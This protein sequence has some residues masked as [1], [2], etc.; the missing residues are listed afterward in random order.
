[1][2]IRTPPTAL[3]VWVLVPLLSV[4]AAPVPAARAQFAPAVHY[5]AGDGPNSVAIGDLDGDQVPDLAMTTYPGWPASGGSV[6]VLLGLG[7]GMFADAVHYAAG[8]GP[9]S[10]AIGDLDG[11]QVPDLAVA[12]GLSDSVSVL[13]GLGD[14][15]FAA[16]A[17]YAAGDGPL[18]VSIGD[19]DGDQI[20]D[21]AVASLISNNVSVLLGLG[22]GT[23]AA[24]KHY[25]AGDEPRSVAIGDLDGDQVLDLAV[26][27]HWYGSFEDSTVSVLLGL[28]D[29]TFAAAVNYPVG[30]WPTSVAIGDLDGDQDSDLVVIASGV[31]SVLLGVGNG[32][33][34]ATRHYYPPAGDG[35][36]SVAI[37][38][39]DGDQVPDLAVANFGSSQPY[40]GTVSVLLGVGDGTF[41]DAVHYDTGYGSGSVAIGDLDGDQAPDLAVANWFSHTVSVL[42]NQS[43]VCY[44]DCDPNGVLDIFDF[45]CFQNSFVLGE[46]YA[47]D[48]DPDPACD[49]FDFLCFQNAFVGGCP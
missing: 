5:A 41:A 49:I 29:G 1:M 17:H 40:D 45:L 34:S 6:L 37:G 16:A 15:T 3:G 47:C 7:D 24:A 39:L 44:A 9:N 8:D 14:G 36:R 12:N 26:T 30:A 23:F 28:G 11:D 10:V 43:Q 13:L 22:D 21:L 48:C 4:I 2:T 38:D 18:S 27:N 19:L 46:P 32:T 20:P 33:F 42:L 35:P 25:T 31:V